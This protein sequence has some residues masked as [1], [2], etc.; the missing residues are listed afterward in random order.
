MHSEDKHMSVG[1]SIARCGGRRF[2]LSLGAG[3]VT[4]LL[5]IA[6]YISEGV[7]ADLIIATVAAYIVGNGAQKYTEARYGR[8]GSEVPKNSD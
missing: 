6:G 3:I 7:Y 1:E 5:L 2:T 4:T 8:S